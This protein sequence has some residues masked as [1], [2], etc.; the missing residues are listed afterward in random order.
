MIVR[1]W[2]NYSG[3]KRFLGFFVLL[4]F[5]FISRE[6][7][8]CF[9]RNSGKKLV[10]S[11]ENAGRDSGFAL[12][13]PW[14]A[15]LGRGGGCSCFTVVCLLPRWLGMADFFQRERGV[16]VMG[17]ENHDGCCFV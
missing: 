12:T 8:W 17:V 6:T 3:T 11:S 7:S 14:R 4:A 9:V 10:V 15:L 1:T 13:L 16:F 2:C 5:G